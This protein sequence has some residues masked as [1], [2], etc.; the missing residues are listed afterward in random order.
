MDLPGF[1]EHRAWLQLRA[2]T[3][4]F[5]ALMMETACPRCDHSPLTPVAGHPRHH[6]DFNDPILREWNKPKLVGIVGLEH[7]QQ[8]WL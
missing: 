6:D 8:V 4:I 3:P 5:W 2:E 7:P 1:N